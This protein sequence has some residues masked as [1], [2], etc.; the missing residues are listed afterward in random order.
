MLMSPPPAPSTSIEA[1]SPLDPAQIPVIAPV[2]PTSGSL[3]KAIDTVSPRP[4]S[5]SVSNILAPV[6]IPEEETVDDISGS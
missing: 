6:L 3:E 1:T 5:V 4:P 2:G